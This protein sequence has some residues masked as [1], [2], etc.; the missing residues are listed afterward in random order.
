MSNVESYQEIEPYIDAE[1]NKELFISRHGRTVLDEFASEKLFELKSIKPEEQQSSSSGYE[2]NEIG[3]A[4]L[5]GC[6]YNKEARYCQ[7]Y[8]KWY[9]Y[10]NGA[11]RK[12]MSEVLVA[13]KLKDF[14][15]IMLIYCG[16]I[17]DDELRKQY[18]AFI[19][20]VG[21]RRMRD[22]ILKDAMGEMLIDA[23]EFDSNPYL[24]NCLNGTYNLK[25]M[26]FTEH[27][28]DDF[29]TMQ[30]NFDYTVMRIEPLPRWVQ[31]IDEITQGDKEKAEFIQ[32]AL[33]YSLLGSSNE[34]CMFIAHGATTRNGKSTLL[35]TVGKILGDYAGSPPVSVITKAERAKNAEAA[36]PH[37]ASLKGKRFVHFEES[38]EYGRLDESKIKQMTGGTAITARN[39][40]ESP[41]TFTPQCTM[42]LSC[43]D[44]PAVRDKSI[45]ASDRIKLIP[46]NRHFKKSER[47]TTLEKQFSQPDAKKGIF[48]WLLEG[49][50]LYKKKGLVSPE[51]VSQAVSQYE[52][53]NDLVMQFLEERCEKTDKGGTLAKDLYDAYSSWCKR[54]GFFICNRKKFCAGIDSHIEWYDKKFVSHGQLKYDGIILKSAVGIKI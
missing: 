9:T 10:Y 2:W 41:V 3:M 25:T 36:N 16:E 54:N 12:D 30:A 35:E 20:K 19:N 39:L 40:Y 26:T 33:G 15:R 42:W 21:D 45:F 4:C 1:M 18:T 8:K 50:R 53:D 52:K 43:N 7:K 23:A 46:F 48:A 14:F 6:L 38:D 51:C 17:I 24:I 49:Y 37:L 47:D 34:H 29:L 5:F 44:L 22:R 28:W 31:F 13:E 32:I 27:K 11:W